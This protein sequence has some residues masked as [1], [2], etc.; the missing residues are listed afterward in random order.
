MRPTEAHL[1]EFLKSK[2]MTFFIPPFQRNYEWERE[3]C[4]IFWDD[5]IK[6]FEQNSKRGSGY[7]V[8]HFFGTVTYFKDD[9]PSWEP[10]R[11]VLIDGQQRITTTMLFLAALRD[12]IF[13]AD[14]KQNIDDNWLRNPKAAKTDS[15]YKIKLKQ[16]EADAKTYSKIILG[17]EFDTRDKASACCLNYLFFRDQIASFVESGGEPMLLLDEALAKFSVILVELEPKKNAWERP[18]EIFESMNSI[19]KPLS[20]SDLVR[21]RLL[22]GFDARKQEELYRKYWLSME[23]TLPKMTSAF[24]RDYMQMTERHYYPVASDANHKRLY[25]Q[26]KGIYTMAPD[27]LLERLSQYAGIYA[28]VALRGRPT[29]NA[30]IDL[31]LDDFRRLEMTTA[32]PFLMALLWEWKKRGFSDKDMDDMLGAFKIYGLRRRLIVGLTSAE[33]K[34]FPQYV[35]FI[36]ELKK[37]KNKKDRLFDL[38]SIRESTARLP[39]D[40]ELTAE[41]KNM[42]NFYSVK[43]SRFYLA[44]IEE[45][46]TKM[47]PNLSDGITQVEHIMPQTPTK[48]WKEE[49]GGDDSKYAQY[50]NSIGNLTLIRHNSEL[51]NKPFAEKKKIYSENES[52]Q[53]ARSRI[54]DKDRWNVSAIEERTD[55]IVKYLLDKVLPIPDKMRTANN[56]VVKEQSNSKGTRKPGLSFDALDLIGKEIVFKYDASITARVVDDNHAEFEGRVMLMSPLTKLVME[57]LGKANKSGAY[58]G[59]Q[60]WKYEGTLLAE[61]M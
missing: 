21:N 27:K 4:H 5:V 55:W 10:D 26:F 14:Q 9:G 35:A 42:A 28:M 44:L 51:G 40:R 52:L 46:L 53:I 29:G 48:A 54:I 47:R 15:E 22:L 11:F 45:S 13:D 61:M 57:R 37:A 59:A 56:F 24:I 1:I 32:R 18:Q 49:F 39:N 33:N 50:V 41:L 38:L 8:E 3:Q 6:T 43:Q 19:G 58:Q 7:G 25:G 12:T 20:L 30:K 17:E 34:N 60:Y 2:D 23:E 31:H 36:P 16:V